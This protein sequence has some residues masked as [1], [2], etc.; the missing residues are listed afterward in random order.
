MKM[1][2]FQLLLKLLEM[3]TTKYKITI[4]ANHTYIMLPKSMVG[5]NIQ[6][7][8]VADKPAKKCIIDVHVLITNKV[9]S[10]LRVLTFI[11]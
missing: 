4:N 6:H 7:S 9:G 11:W 5:Q 10:I 1:I 8:N 2:K 3:I